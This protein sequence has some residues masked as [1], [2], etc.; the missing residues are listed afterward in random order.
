MHISRQHLLL[1]PA[2][3]VN[4]YGTHLSPPTL[5][6]GGDSLTAGTFSFELR[7]ITL[8]PH[9]HCPARLRSPQTDVVVSVERVESLDV[10]IGAGG[11][12]INVGLSASVGGVMPS[13][14]LLN[15]LLPSGL[16]L[17]LSSPGIQVSGS[18][19]GSG[20]GS[21]EARGPATDVSAFTA[22]AAAAVAAA[23][24]PT[25][26]GPYAPKPEQLKVRLVSLLREAELLATQLASQDPAGTR[27]LVVA[28]LKGGSLIGNW[29]SAPPSQQG[30]GASG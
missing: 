24:L 15:T 1:P 19:G 6:W 4:W 10:L 21:T 9:H 11:G 25:D 20:N 26:G 12:N 22:A 7:Q 28:A 29:C 2:P 23:N 27:A 8:T 17:P 3:R 16:T 14:R 30:S 13:G 5:G 18:A